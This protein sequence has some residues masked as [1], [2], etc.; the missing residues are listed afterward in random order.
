MQRQQDTTTNAECQLR[1]NDSPDQRRDDDH[2]LQRDHSRP[3]GYRGLSASGRHAAKA[4][5]H[6]RTEGRKGP[7]TLHHRPSP[8]PGFPEYGFGFAAGC[9]CQPGNC[10]TDLRQQEEAL[11]RRHYQR[12]RAPN[13]SE[14]ASQRQSTSRSGKCP[15]RQRSQQ[16][17]LHGCEESCKWRRRH[18]TISSGRLGEQQH[19]PTPHYRQRQQPDVRLL[20]DC[21]RSAAQHD[22]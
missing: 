9:Q 19:A 12:R 2:K 3:T 13:G 11:R 5:R 7:D 22:A 6:R 14:H 10:T 16:P 15:G 21:R 8:I 17:Q 4:L 18:P 20:R 1:D